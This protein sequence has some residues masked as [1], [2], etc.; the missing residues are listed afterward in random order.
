M[1]STTRPHGF[2]HDEPGLADTMH[3]LETQVTDAAEH[4]RSN[5]IDRAATVTLAIAARLA[6]GGQCTKRF[7]RQIARHLVETEVQRPVGD[8]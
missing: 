7:A 1:A 8:R 5:D 2:F 3:G 4:F 6:V